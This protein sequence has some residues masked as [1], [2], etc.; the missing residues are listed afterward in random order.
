[1]TV[2]FR[3]D[4]GESTDLLG[5][6]YSMTVRRGLAASGLTDELSPGT[7]TAVIKGSPKANPLTNPDVRPDRRI[8]LL[9][10]LADPAT[11][12]VVDWHVI[13]TGTIKRAR[14]EYDPAAKDDPDAYRVHITALDR[15]AVLAATP[16][17]TSVSGTVTQ[18]VAA[19]LDPTGIPYTVTDNEPATTSIVL[20]SEGRTVVE[21]LRLIRDT[22]HAQ[23]FVDRDDRVQVV[24]DN[25]RARTVP[26]GEFVAT[27]DPDGGPAGA[28]HYHDL[29]PVFDTDAVVNLLTIKHL[30][31][32]TEETYTDED[33]RAAWGDKPETVTVNDGNTETHAGLYLATRTD[34]ELIPEHLAFFVALADE[35]MFRDEHFAAACA[36]EVADSIEVQRVGLEDHNLLIRD[37]THTITHV[38]WSVGV[39]VRVPEVL[40]TRWDDVPPDLTWDD[41]PAGLTWDTAVNWHPYIEETI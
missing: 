16:A 29:T 28:I 32:G 3:L 10:G 23:V 1:M 31:A 39:G 40:A 5:D 36:I 12:E 20:A 27:D 22:M 30:G 21:Q 9:A 14:L 35:Y 37:I 8:Q 24:A 33:S 34:P 4:A 18:R 38:R 15:V 26:L 6:A 13:F 7:F 11:G 19:V 41:V 2:Q 17:E 25:A